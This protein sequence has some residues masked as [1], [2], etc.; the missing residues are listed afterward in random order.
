MN[1]ELCEVLHAWLIEEDLV[2]PSGRSLM[3]KIV[4]CV[5]AGINREVILFCFCFFPRLRLTVQQT[6]TTLPECKKQAFAV[7]SDCTS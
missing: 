7:R 6:E 1:H 2:R 5:L 3:E 4:E